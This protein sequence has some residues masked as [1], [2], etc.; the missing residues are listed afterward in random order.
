MVN[1]RVGWLFGFAMCLS[2]CG[3]NYSAPRGIDMSVVPSSWKGNAGVK[4]LDTQVEYSDGRYKSG[5]AIASYRVKH[6]RTARVGKPTTFT[7]GA[8]ITSINKT[9]ELAEGTPLYAVQLTQTS[10]TYQDGRLSSSYTQS[11]DENPIEWC[12]PH[13]TKTGALCLFWQGQET[14]FY[15]ENKYGSP[16]MPSVRY[17]SSIGDRSSLPEIIEDDGV[18]FDESLR[19]AIIIGQNNKKYISINHVVGT[20]TDERFRGGQVTYRR[21]KWDDEGRAEFTLWGADI[22][23]ERDGPADKESEYVKVTFKSAPVIQTR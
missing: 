13:P 20:A 11:A 2:A 6:N 1:K 8:G 16:L 4:I 3:T 17:G 12:T 22:L 9:L 14:A 7:S 21:K 10:S 18:T 19:S 5:E 23:I 15:L